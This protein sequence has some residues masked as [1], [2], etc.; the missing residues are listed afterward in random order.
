MK[1]TTVLAATLLLA[2]LATTALAADFVLIANKGNTIS[3]LSENDARQIYLGKKSTWPDG[4][5]IVLYMQQN[6]AVNSTFAEAVAKKTSQQF[7]IY[8]KKA[9]FTG[10]GRPPIEV[11]DDAE[12]KKFIA[13]DPRGI[14]YI[15]R[16]AFDG[17]VKEI[18]IR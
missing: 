14:G 10:T 1:Y 4:Q 15:S 3:S 6:E 16:A 18:N 11:R 12:M 8:W 9:L 7:Q 17:S 5:S 13:A 2:T